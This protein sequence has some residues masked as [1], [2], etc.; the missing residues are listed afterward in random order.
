MPHPTDYSLLKRANASS[1]SLISLGN[2]CLHSSSS[3][4]WVIDSG[5]SD[6]MISNSSLLSHISSTCSPSFVTIANV[7]NTSVQGKGTIT[8]SDLTLS[9]VLYLSLFPFNLLSVHKLTLALNCSVAFYPSHCEFQDLKMKRMI[10][11]G[12]VKD[13]LYYFQPSSTSVPFALPS[14]NSPYP[15]HCCLG[16]PSSV[17]LKHLVP[18]FTYFF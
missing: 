8:T 14:T 9:D 18:H 15:W 12:F 16:H 6:H 10:G 4:S 11:G 3:P 5:A 7:T 13:G 17:N 1:S 2:T